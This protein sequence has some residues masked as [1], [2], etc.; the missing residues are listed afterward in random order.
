MMLKVQRNLIPL[1]SGSFYDELL[2]GGIFIPPSQ[3]ETCFISYSHNE[4]DADKT[5]ETYSDALSK[6]KEVL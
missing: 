6:V 2:R 3:F 1:C 4:D 5:I